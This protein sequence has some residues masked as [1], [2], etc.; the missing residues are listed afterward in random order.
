MFCEQDEPLSVQINV[1]SNLKD[2]SELVIEVTYELLSEGES[3]W[4]TERIEN[5]LFSYDDPQ[6][7]YSAGKSEFK[8]PFLRPV[9]KFAFLCVY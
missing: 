7:M 8:K 2:D 6:P 9:N 4:V 5:S 3:I 1:P